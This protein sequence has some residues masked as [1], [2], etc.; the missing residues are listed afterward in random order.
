MAN[1]LPLRG[2]ALNKAVRMRSVRCDACG[3]RA[4]IAASQCP[5]CGHLL[6]VRDGFGELL[7]LSL[8]PTCDSYYPESLG[9]CRWCGTKP[10]PPP[11][12]TP[13]V[14]KAAGWAGLVIVVAIGWLLRYH[15]QNVSTDIRRAS[16]RIQ[17]S[18]AKLTPDL[19][20]VPG[21]PAD[22]SVATGVANGSVGSDPTPRKASAPTVAPQSAAP[23][24]SVHTPPP[25]ATPLPAPKAKG[26]PRWVTSISKGWVVVRAGPS[27]QSRLVASIGPNSRVQLGESSGTWRRIRA[28]GISGWV[29]PGSLFT[30]V[31]GSSRAHVF[32]SR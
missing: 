19:A 9:A 31:P 11:V 26:S 29:E 21:S 30:E 16:K 18:T 1:V 23:P 5:K 32:S 2:R 3:T 12:I 13:Q 22:T 24:P 17:D 27:R 14:W 4:L 20:D 15:E 10:A 25:T 7:P 6:D 8:C 28:R